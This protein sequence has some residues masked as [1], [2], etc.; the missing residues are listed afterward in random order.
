MAVSPL[1]LT[2]E[3]EPTDELGKE[4]GNED[5]NGIP[6]VD[7]QEDVYKRFLNELD[8]L[9]TVQKM[10]ETEGEAVFDVFNRL[11]PEPPLLTRTHQEAL[12][13]VLPTLR[14]NNY[15][16]D[17]IVWA[18]MPSESAWL[19]ASEQAA[20]IVDEV[21]S[22]SRFTPEQKS[23]L[24]AVGKPWLYADLKRP[25]MSILVRKVDALSN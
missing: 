11:N 17:I 24:R 12:L 18:T 23:H 9:A 22:W 8:R 6:I 13:R 19:N 14:R 15:R 4:S 25:V 20:Q 10:P 2:D 5:D 3:P 21:I 16:V 1:Y 7:R